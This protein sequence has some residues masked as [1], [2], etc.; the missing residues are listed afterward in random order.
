MRR[1]LLEII[2]AFVVGAFACCVFFSII[3]IVTVYIEMPLLKLTKWYRLWPKDYH[4]R[5]YFALFECIVFELFSLIPVTAF[6]G[7][8]LGLT[9]AKRPKL[10]GF[11]AA[12]GAITLYVYGHLSF[13][14]SIDKTL[15]SIREMLS[16]FTIFHIPL[17]IFWVVLFIPFTGTGYRL[18]TAVCNFAAPATDI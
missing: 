15:G 16:S 4:Y 5:I 10:H 8:G 12:L 11:A 17:V 3:G 18:K 13:I 9:I 1:R 6:S 14:Y 2:L 7:T